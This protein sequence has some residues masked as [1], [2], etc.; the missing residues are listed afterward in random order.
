MDKSTFNY[1]SCSGLY[2][3][4]FLEKLGIWENGGIVHDAKYS[5]GMIF[6]LLSLINI[7]IVLVVIKIR[8]FRNQH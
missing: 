5:C 2:S 7:C 6:V 8:F 3:T 4:L 1:S